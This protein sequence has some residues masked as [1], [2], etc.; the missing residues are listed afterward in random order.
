MASGNNKFLPKL[1]PLKD[2][3]TGIELEN[4][5]QNLLF[6]MSD[7]PRFKHLLENPAGLKWVPTSVATNR[8]FI[9][10]TSTVTDKQ[11]AIQKHA[12]LDFMLNTLA[13]YIPVLS[14][15][16]I[17]NQARC[18]N[19]IW[20]RLRV[21]YG[22]K[23]TGGSI[24]QIANLKMNDGE[25]PEAFWERSYAF[26]EGCL[27]DPD[28]DIKHL[29]EITTV[30]ETFT[31]CLLNL[32][33]SLWLK[34]IHTQLPSLVEQRYSKESQDCTIY[35]IRED[36]SMAIPSLLAE[37]E[38]ANISRAQ[39]YKPQQRVSND[40][41]TPPQQQ[42]SLS[43]TPP[44]CCLCKS[45]NRSPDAHFMTRCPYLPAADK[46]YLKNLQS[47]ANA[48]MVD[49]N[50]NPLNG[51][52]SAISSEDYSS[53]SDNIAQL[54][55]DIRRVSVEQ[56]PILEANYGDMT[57]SIILDSGA[58]ANLISYDECSRLK[59]P[60]FENCQGASQADGKT[61]LEILG[62]SHIKFTFSHHTLYFNCLVV[63]NLGCSI[64]AG[65]P[66]HS[67]NDIFIRM[68]QQSI[69][70]GD[71]CSTQ[72]VTSKS[73][74]TAI[75]RPVNSINRN[76]DFPLETTPLSECLDTSQL[77]LTSVLRVA[78]Q[79]TLL[80]GEGLSFVIPRSFRGEEMVAIEPRLHSQSY[81]RYAEWLHPSIQ[82]VHDG[83]IT[84]YNMS[85]IPVKLARNEQICNIR[86]T[87]IVKSTKTKPIYDHRNVKVNTTCTSDLP[88]GTFFSDSVR[89]DPSNQLSE[90]MK[91]K[92]QSV[93]R[94]YDDTFNPKIG[95]YNGASGHFEARVHMGKT[96]PPQ[97]KGRMPKYSHGD[98]NILQ[99]KMDNLEDQN[100]L[101]TA[102]KVDIDI[103]YLNLS[104]L[105]RKKDG[106]ARYVTSFGEVAEYAKPQP[107]LMSNAED[108]LR[109]VCQ[110]KFIVQTDLSDSYYQLPLSRDSMKYC[111][112][113]TPFKGSRVYTRCAMGMP[114]SEVALEEILC[115]IL[116]DLIG[117][118]CVAK[119]ADDMFCGGDSAEDALLVWE[120]V[121]ERL[122]RNGLRLSGK[123][124]VCCP[125]TT[126]ILGW[127]WNNGVISASPHRISALEVVKPP[128]TVHGL[129]SFLGAFKFVS[130][131]LP[132]FC[133]IL[134]PLET[135]ISNR[136]SKEKIEWTDQLLDAFSAAQ[137][138]LGSAKSLVIPHAEDEL[139][140]ITDASTSKRGLAATLYVVRAGKLKLAGFF[141][142]KMKPFQS[143]WLPCEQEGLCIGSAIEFFAPYIIQSKHRTVV[144]TDSLPCVQAY[145]KLR[146]GEFSSSA[147]VMT[148]VSALSNYGVTLNHIRGE[149]NLI[150]DYSSRNP[151]ECSDGSCQLCKYVD[152][153][154]NSAFHST[155]RSV[156]INDI[157]NNHMD[158]FNNRK[159]WS[160]IQKSCSDLRRVHA[161]LDQ[162]TEPPK[163]A[164]NMS[165][166]RSYLSSTSHVKI[167]NDGLLVVPAKPGLGPQKDRIV[168]P[169]SVSHG[170]ITALH[171]KLNHPSKH[172]L[173]KIV[174]RQF[175]ALGMEN[176][177]DRIYANCDVC[178]ALK[179]VPT[180]FQEQSTSDPPSVIGQEFSADVVRRF[181]QCILVLRENV[182]AFTATCLIPDET[183]PSYR[184]GIVV[185]MS[186]LRSNHGHSVRIRVD[187]APGL[188][189]I[190]SDKVLSRLGI[191]LEIGDEKNV[192][193][194]PIAEHAISELHG[195]L[196]RLQPSGGPSSISTLAQATSNMNSCLRESGLSATE[197]W[198]QR[199]QYSGE[200]LPLSDRRI[201][202]ERVQQRIASHAS[203]EKYK[204]RGQTTPIYPKVKIGDLVY[205]HNDRDKTKF[206]DRYI[207]I[208]IAH[209]YCFVQKFVGR[210]LRSHRYRVHLSNIYPVISSI[211]MENFKEL[212]NDSDE[213]DVDD[214]NL[215]IHDHDDDDVDLDLGSDDHARDND[216]DS[217][218]SGDGVLPVYVDDD[219]N[220]LPDRGGGIDFI[221]E[222]AISPPRL[223]PGRQR[224]LPTRF[225]DYDLSCSSD[226][227]EG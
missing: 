208:S 132:S 227:D 160:D 92:F 144:L 72:Y 164:K 217:N 169:R 75:P 222:N 32:L 226:D 129:R 38:T 39:Y 90:E 9:D 33:V 134:H 210:Q 163:K 63:R 173:R 24:L 48:R 176:I 71:C 89:V 69:H 65:V 46:L 110:W 223:F 70:F 93:N 155:F 183:G 100:V 152:D 221:D 198:T 148:F 115:R 19:D 98:K 117:K 136:K 219:L 58:E 28:D 16:F 67:Y 61:P 96:E 12:T 180:R 178:A 156:N 203:S 73:K 174:Y 179:T 51:Q 50:D 143:L 10:D 133:D 151:I 62:E 188:R 127:V 195:Q 125:A 25:S 131:V 22:C 102:E 194:N 225:K 105:M 8:G 147:R 206:R 122:H 27:L 192:N 142:A 76:S 128:E 200:Q 23:K 170:I 126:T 13:S 211:I 191:S 168:I 57:V 118:G 109:Q 190:T 78:S 35:T 207:V 140:I 121:L 149:Q 88:S 209:P 175:F 103:E 91:I 56:S 212:N 204:A 54:P 41:P 7:V 123:K 86:R 154:S 196:L 159:A 111:G 112:V 166:V 220:I 139:R 202:H 106:G 197:I 52:Y 101:S 187:P 114:G 116:G 171:L 40:K 130:K 150:S 77:P 218:N 157:L 199:D 55:V 189:S 6:Q 193:K 64:L 80:P 21:Y 31:P 161:H 107:S 205:I 108:T 37:I 1:E 66:F 59:A 99:D 186:R 215:S 47:R 17:V 172:Q 36:I 138:H 162:G 165:E 137:R 79:T 30:K 177:L 153:S 11:T 83:L 224:R 14:R 20:M 84:V 158:I 167:A 81:E 45:A 60:I 94:K 104:F 182:S 113:S 201:I 87:E 214:E 5:R 49:I 124:T 44:V 34:G 82:R 95:C 145:A 216:V 97:R 53:L 181:K 42:L 120:Q 185:L 85:T 213:S 29:G 18:L 26:M 68:N 3:V 74:R 184:D 119:I 15:S 146:R 4:F 141:N 2:K 43:R 135:V